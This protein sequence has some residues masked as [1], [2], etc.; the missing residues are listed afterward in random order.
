MQVH[1]CRSFADDPDTECA[2]AKE[3]EE[4]ADEVVL[5]VFIKNRYFDDD[6]FVDHP[7]KDFVQYYYYPLNS[8]LG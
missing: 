1:S 2:S 7:V 5:D 4:L 8:V 6:E 3:I